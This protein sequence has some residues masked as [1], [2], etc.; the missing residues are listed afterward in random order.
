MPPTTQLYNSETRARGDN[1]PERSL[2]ALGDEG[3]AFRR[4]QR[5][6]DLFQKQFSPPM[7][8]A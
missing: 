7:S 2:R 8:Q 4:S 1:L 3:R 5:G 6:R